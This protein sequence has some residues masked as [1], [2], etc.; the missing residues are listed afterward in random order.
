MSEFS[1]GDIVWLKCG[2]PAMVIKLICAD[3]SI[4]CEWF[5]GDKYHAHLFHPNTLINQKPSAKAPKI[6]FK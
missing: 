5:G 3:K 6:D 1:V 4:R 2:G